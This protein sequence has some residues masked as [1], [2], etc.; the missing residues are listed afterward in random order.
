MNFVLTN[1][2]IQQLRLENEALKQQVDGLKGDLEFIER[3]AVHQAR[4]CRS[5][6]SIIH[7]P[8]AVLNVIADYQAIRD[9]TE[10]FNQPPEEKR[11]KFQIGRQYETQAGEL[12]TVLA[13]A[14]IFYPG[15]ECLVCSDGRYRYDRST[16]D[17]DAGRCTGTSH[18][19][20]Y[21]HNFKK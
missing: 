6:G 2:D 14:N 11:F 13:R 9:I 20:S 7:S 16:S 1:E 10:S 19:Y 18:D 4:K 5:D 17:S 12:V 21:S 3:W 15:Y 8:A